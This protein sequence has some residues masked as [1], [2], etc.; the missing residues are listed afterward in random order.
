HSTDPQ[1]ERLAVAAKS[2]HQEP[3]GAKGDEEADGGDDHALAA[4]V[5]E[6]L[7]VEGEDTGNHDGS[8]GHGWKEGPP[9]GC[10]KSAGRSAT[11]ERIISAGS[12]VTQGSTV[13]MRRRIDSGPQIARRPCP[14]RPSV[15]RSAPPLSRPR[16]D[17]PCS[18][19]CAPQRCGA[20]KPF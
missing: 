6:V 9:A 18:A 11:L 5:P 17:E 16:R 4:M 8:F 14:T 15:R 2:V 13:E 19:G 1:L 12:A 20:S 10:P 3:R 7:P